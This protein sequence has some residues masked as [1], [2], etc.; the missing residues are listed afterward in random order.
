MSDKPT[1]CDCCCFETGALTAYRHESR[2]KADAQK[3]L[4]D[5]CAETEAGRMLDYPSQFEGQAATI[6]TVCYVGNVILKAL[7]TRS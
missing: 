2:L 6:R 4:C 3:W 5:L 1:C 7:K